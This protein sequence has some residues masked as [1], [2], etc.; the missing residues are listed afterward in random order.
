MHRKQNPVFDA[1]FAT[2]PCDSFS[3]VFAGALPAAGSE[4]DGKIA[5]ES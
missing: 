3:A 1:V 2:G 5:I 4:I